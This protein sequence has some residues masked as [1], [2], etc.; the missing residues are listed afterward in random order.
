MAKNTLEVHIVKMCKKLWNSTKWS[1]AGFRYAFNNELSF[2]LEFLLF[3][4]L[5]PIAIFLAADVNQL[6]FLL[7]SCYTVLIVELINTAIEV[8][9][10]RIGLEHNELSKHA[11]DVGSAAV[12][13]SIIFM[14][15]VWSI[16][17]S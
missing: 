1:L 15:L 13:L 4:L 10:D 12:F 14:L 8:I 17:R 6:F 5:T 3:M 9:V 16:S 2:K 11:K 7:S